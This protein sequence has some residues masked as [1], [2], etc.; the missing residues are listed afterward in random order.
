MVEY[1]YACHLEILYDVFFFL[2]LHPFEFF[3]SRTKEMEFQYYY[4]DFMNHKQHKNKVYT[5]NFDVWHFYFRKVDDGFCCCCW[6]KRKLIWFFPLLRS[7]YIFLIRSQMYN[8]HHNIE[9]TNKYVLEK[10]SK[11]S[12]VIYI[13]LFITMSIVC[14]LL[15]IGKMCQYGNVSSVISISSGFLALSFSISQNFNTQ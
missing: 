7:I 12:I 1:I 13:S 8:V 10:E 3:F 5:H 9:S 4:Y 14:V 11:H 6:A 15:T 2:L